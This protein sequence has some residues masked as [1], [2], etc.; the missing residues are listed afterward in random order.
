MIR[1]DDNYTS[2]IT[3]NPFSTTGG[4]F[5]NAAIDCIISSYII[6]IIKKYPI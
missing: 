5:Q 2:L 6:Q 3:N 1:I 4:F